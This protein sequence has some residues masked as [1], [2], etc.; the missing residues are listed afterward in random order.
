MSILIRFNRKWKLQEIDVRKRPTVLNQ[1]RIERP[2]STDERYVRY[3]LVAVLEY[4]KVI[5]YRFL[6]VLVHIH[7]AALAEEISSLHRCYILVRLHK[8]IGAG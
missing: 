6:Y 5:Y 7:E 2:E 3:Y 4:A 8:W 1:W